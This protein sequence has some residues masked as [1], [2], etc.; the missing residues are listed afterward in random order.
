VTVVYFPWLIMTLIVF[1]ISLAG[2]KSK[3]KHL[4]VPNWL[5]M[6]GIIENLSMATQIVMTFKFGTWRYIFPLIA[7]Y[8]LYMLANPVFSVVFRFKIAMKDPAFVRWQS[9]PENRTTKAVLYFGG[10]IISWKFY[11]LLYSHFWG[12]NIKSA[13]K[14]P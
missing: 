5:V 3:L 2:A 14:K 7:A 4:L 8:G 11:K 1:G 9:Q 6:M 12:Y 13:F 10:T